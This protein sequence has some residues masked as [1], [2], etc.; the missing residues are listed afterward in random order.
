MNQFYDSRNR[1]SGSND[2]KSYNYEEEEIEKQQTNSPAAYLDTFVT[3]TS[4][5]SLCIIL[6]MLLPYLTQI[7]WFTFAFIINSNL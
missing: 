4:H 3:L 2:S 5:R 6:V 1:S 7:I